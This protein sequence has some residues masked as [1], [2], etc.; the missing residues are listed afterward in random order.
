MHTE[1]EIKAIAVS[2]FKT[3]KNTT[4][5]NSII[6]EQRLNQTIFKPNK[7]EATNWLIKFPLMW[8]VHNNNYSNHIRHTIEIM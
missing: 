2:S 1:H 7:T 4:E 6:S 3:T 5:M 8:Q